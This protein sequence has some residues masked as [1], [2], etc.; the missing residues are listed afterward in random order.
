MH[1]SQNKVHVVFTVKKE[2][3]K[4][5][6]NYITILKFSYYEEQTLFGQVPLLEI[7]DE[8]GNVAKLA[9]SSTIAR[10]LG[11]KFNLVGK[12]ELEQAR[13]EMILDHF[14]DLSGHFRVWIMEAD[15]ELK[16][17][18]FKKFSQ[19]HLPH[20][21]GLVEKLLE[22]NRTEYLAGNEVTSECMFILYIS[23]IRIRI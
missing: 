2:D 20:S 19:E 14:M 4:S 11:R 23:S 6:I 17:E 5:S 18:K 7:N 15:E 22:Q 9:Q 3:K 16:E 8:N 13:A 10:Y 12:D 1:K 21:V